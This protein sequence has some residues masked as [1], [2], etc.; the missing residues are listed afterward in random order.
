MENIKLRINL[1]NS[2]ETKRRNFSRPYSLQITRKFLKAGN[3]FRKE[4]HLRYLAGF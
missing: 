3:Y 2:C 1:G 4:F